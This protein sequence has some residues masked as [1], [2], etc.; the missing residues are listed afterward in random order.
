M[1][2]TSLWSLLFVAFMLNHL[3][4][5]TESSFTVSVSADSLALGNR[6]LVEYQIKNGNLAAPFS[7]P[8][9]TGFE[10][11]GNRTG[12]Q[13]NM[14]NGQMT[15]YST[16]TYELRPTSEGVLFID[17]VVI[18]LQ[19]GTFLETDPLEIFVVPNADP[20]SPSRIE[21]QLP[22]T[23]LDIFGEMNQAIP[24]SFPPSQPAPA[25]EPPKESKKKRKVIKM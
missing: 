4:A 8:S 7:P 22:G 24:P 21:G 6:I 18:E 17:P 10:I 5:Q 16:F 15:Q 11:L 20:Q 25:P 2:T 9:F 19:D 13:I 3:N 12:N 23:R 14:I 1:K